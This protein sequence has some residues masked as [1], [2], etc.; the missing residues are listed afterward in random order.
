METSKVGL[1][2]FLLSGQMECGGLKRKGS[3]RLIDLN[4]WLEGV[5]I[6]GGI[7]P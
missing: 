2:K 4:A 5:V 1:N 3:H 6:L 7:W